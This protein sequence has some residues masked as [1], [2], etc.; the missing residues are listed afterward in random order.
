M[1]CKCFQSHTTEGWGF[2]LITRK[3]FQSQTSEGWGFDFIAC[4]CYTG[5]SFHSPVEMPCK[6]V[7]TFLYFSFVASGSHQ[8]KEPVASYYW[9]PSSIQNISYIFSTR[10]EIIHG[11]HSLYNVLILFSFNL[12][13]TV[14][15]IHQRMRNG[16]SGR[17]SEQP[18]ACVS[19]RPQLFTNY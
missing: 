18:N 11:S 4:K 1:S 5:V 14:S 12:V 13:I 10:I 7:S 3:C 15:V 8:A 2:S 16:H 9:L 6:W 17:E 19:I